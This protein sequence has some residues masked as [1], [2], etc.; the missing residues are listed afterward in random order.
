MIYIFLRERVLLTFL[1][2]YS[3]PEQSRNSS[4]GIKKTIRSLARCGVTRGHEDT[5]VAIRRMVLVGTGTNT[6]ALSTPLNPSL[7]PPGTGYISTPSPFLFPSLH[8]ARIFD[9]RAF[10]TYNLRLI[11]DSFGRMKLSNFFFNIIYGDLMSSR[12]A[13]TTSREASYTIITFTLTVERG[14]DKRL[15]IVFISS[16]FVRLFFYLVWRQMVRITC[17]P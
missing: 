15:K 6:T 11:P 7:V 8:Q 17:P 13:I 12:L 9:R 3:P 4:M 2:K 14:A 1:T 5:R 16:L 10:E